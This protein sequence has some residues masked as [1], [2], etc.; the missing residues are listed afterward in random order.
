ML[1]RINIAS[2]TYSLSAMYIFLHALLSGQT[3]LT[4]YL[5]AA[6]LRVPLPGFWCTANI[7]RVLNRLLKWIIKGKS[8]WRLSV[9]I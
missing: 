6:Y 1:Q 2:V 7:Q 9:A 4:L 8:P 3:N 5:P